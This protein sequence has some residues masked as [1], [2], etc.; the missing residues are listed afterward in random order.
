M[1]LI[2]TGW[3]VMIR[4]HAN[5][6]MIF[7]SNQQSRIFILLWW[8][9]LPIDHHN[10]WKVLII[11]VYKVFRKFFFPHLSASVKGKDTKL[12]F[13]TRWLSHDRNDLWTRIFPFSIDWFL[14]LLFLQ[15]KYN[16]TIGKGMILTR[17]I[18]RLAWSTSTIYREQ[19]TALITLRRISPWD[20]YYH[21]SLI[22][23]FQFYPRD[24]RM[25]E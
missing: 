1:I 7:S 2:H 15:D 18:L 5:L 24:N 25:Q 3:V 9:I 4:K 22:F 8:V 23:R 17:G 19:S 6:G 12:L 20:Y 10:Q 11:I 13:P 21:C 16:E 14:L